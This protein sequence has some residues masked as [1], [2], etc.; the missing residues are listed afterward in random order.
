MTTKITV[1]A[2][3]GWP[4]QVIRRLRNQ[5]PGKESDEIIV[6]ANTQKDIHIWDDNEL[7]VREMKRPE[8]V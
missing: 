1:D 3:A 2:H 8:G 5:P 6:Q 7:I 4:V